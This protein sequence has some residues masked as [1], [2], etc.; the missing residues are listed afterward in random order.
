VK[1]HK[2]VEIKEGNY[3]IIFRFRKTERNRKLFLRNDKISERSMLKCAFKPPPISAVL[4]DAN[5]RQSSPPTVL[6][7]M[8]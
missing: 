1:R 3:N 8:S 2:D 5:N 4:S 7:T 6:N